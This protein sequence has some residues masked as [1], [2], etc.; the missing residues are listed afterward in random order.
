MHQLTK[1]TR[2][3]ASVLIV[4]ALL[5]SPN[6]TFIAFGQQTTGTANQRPVSHGIRDVALDSSGQLELAI[7]DGTG[8]PVADV[9]VLI[10]YHGTPVA[11]AKSNAKGTVVVAGLKAGLHSVSTPFNSTVF[12]FW[13]ARQAPPSSLKRP[14]VALHGQATRGQYGP[15]MG[16]PMQPM[17]GPAM[18]AP[19]LLATGVTATA[20]AVVLIGKSEGDDAVIVPASP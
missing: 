8:R 13:T 19:G 6:G 10:A 3:S 7:V 5:C 16:Y 9:V 11:R 20:V 1:S 12:R 17:M 14:A 4:A 2:S 15:M 18:M